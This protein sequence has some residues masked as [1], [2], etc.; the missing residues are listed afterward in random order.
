MVVKVRMLYLEKYLKNHL[1]SLCSVSRKSK[2]PPEL[3]NLPG[4]GGGHAGPQPTGR[5]KKNMY[6]N[7]FSLT[8]LM[9]EYL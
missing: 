2:N 5:E 3:S 7:M 6:K 1:R 4:G 8:R 9:V